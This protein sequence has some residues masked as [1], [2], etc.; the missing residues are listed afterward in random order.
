MS[1]YHVVSSGRRSTP[2]PAP[3]AEPGD[4]ARAPRL[5]SIQRA[6]GSGS[7]PGGASHALANSST[8]AHLGSRLP[9]STADTDCL[10]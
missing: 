4:C 7:L 9:L 3:T 6:C 8:N 5:I 1:R 2:A 10:L